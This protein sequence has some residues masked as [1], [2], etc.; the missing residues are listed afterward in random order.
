M[1]IIDK[2]W[3]QD[4]KTELDFVIKDTS[5]S[6]DTID[7]KVRE[8]DTKRVK[9]CSDGHVNENVRGNRKY[10]VFCKSLLQD[11]QDTPGFTFDGPLGDSDQPPENDMTNDETRALYYMLVDNINHEYVPVEKSLGAIDINPNNTD[12]IRKVL[13]H[14]KKKTELDKH[15]CVELLVDGQNILKK[16]INNE[17]RRSW[18]LLTCDDLPMKSLIKLI[19]NTFTCTTC[20]KRFEDISDISEHTEKEEHCSYF[21]TYGCFLPNYGQFHYMMCMYR[22]YLKLLWNIEYK[23]LAISI[24]LTSPK[25][26]L[27]VEKGQ[28]FRKSLDFIITAR[29]A[30]IREL[31]S[32]FVKY[33]N[34]QKIVPTIPNF[35]RWVKEVVNSKTYQNVFNIEHKYGTPLVLFRSSYRAN[36]LRILNACK[37]IFS[38]LFHINHNSNYLMLDMW[39]QYFD[40]KMKKNNP[41]LAS[42][43]EKRLFCNKSGRPYRS[44]PFDELHEE[45]NRKGMR[46]QNNKTEKEF[47]NSFTIVN[48]YVEM[49]D[50]MLSEMG[51]NE[52]DNQKFRSQNLEPNIL[53]MRI[54]MRQNKY[55]SNPEIIENVFSLNGEELDES[56]L[57]INTLAREA[58]QENIMH[59]LNSGNF[60]TRYPSKKCDFYEK[61]SVTID[62]EQQIKILISSIEDDSQREHV[63][64]YWKTQKRDK[65]YDEASFFD[66]LLDNKINIA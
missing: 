15:Y 20:G 24:K 19:E 48:E 44:E 23:D 1:E 26:L 65:E 61:D 28:D 30:K 45:F 4:L 46:F 29:K 64:K 31:L 9:V 57:N 5:N 16:V 35:K 13:D 54:K 52:E 37:N 55:L 2:F 8:N 33:A 51:L 40:L 42:Y 66:D 38:S 6:H 21:Q 62:F 14:I 7:I 41:E 53:D 56:I 47:A 36:N 12:R 3:D 49:R 27:M 39:T 17:D 50:S 59:V 63:Y 18:V 34:A 58:R 11:A 25:A 10:C 43:L 22:S 60:F 32:P